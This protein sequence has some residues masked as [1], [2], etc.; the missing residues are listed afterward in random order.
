MHGSFFGFGQIGRVFL[1]QIKKS[2]L[3]MV[4]NV[5]PVLPRQQ[6]N[7]EDPITMGGKTRWEYDYDIFLTY[8]NRY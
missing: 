1:S 5:I 8:Y 3:T 6:Q 4:Q 2:D 7:D